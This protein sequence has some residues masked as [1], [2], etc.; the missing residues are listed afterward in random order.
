[1]AIKTLKRV[2]QRR[3]TLQHRNQQKR[4][5]KGGS[6]I[7]S[8]MSRLFGSKPKISSILNSLIEEKKAVTAS[9]TAL[10]KQIIKKEREKRE[11]KKQNAKI[12][13]KKQT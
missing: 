5:Q 2:H 11:K 12:Y 1:M 10:P 6:S 8:S 4:T 13:V 3:R 7:V 9:V